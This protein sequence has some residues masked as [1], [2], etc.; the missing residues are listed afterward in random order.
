[1]SKR[2]FTLI[3]LLVVIAII[4]ILAAI[5]LPALQAAR[6]RAKASSCVSNLKQC[7]T[8][9][10][11]Y[12]NDHRNWWPVG[13]STVGSIK[14]QDD[15]AGTNLRSNNYLY[16]LY[17]GKY[18]G[19]GIW[20]GSDPGSFLCP[21]MTINKD[22]LKA[23]WP[24][25]YGSQ[26]VHNSTVTKTQLGY[27]VNMSGFS[28]GYYSYANA[29]KPPASA[30]SPDTSSVGPSSRVLLCDNIDMTQGGAMVSQLY[31]MSYSEKQG[32][33]VPYLMH[34]GRSALL[35]LDGHVASAD[36]GELTTDYWFPFFGANLCSVRTV[37]YC[38]DGPVM[39]L[40]VNK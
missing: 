35:T 31:I 26:Y 29:S 8:T 36:E 3:E 12:I 27:S 19:I 17:K 7:G 23:G 22:T 38:L 30:P 39:A 21:G 40:E 10:Q 37:R 28:R 33:G 16:N 1:M 4:A 5:L 2:S 14:V 11:S 18:A 24:Q 20:N 6:M 25:G 13:A 15:Y 32:Y 34:N 9:A